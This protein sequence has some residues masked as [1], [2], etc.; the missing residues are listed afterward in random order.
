MRPLIRQGAYP[1]QARALLQGPLI[2][3]NP[4]KAAGR[5]H[6]PLRGQLGDEDTMVMESQKLLYLP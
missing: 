1:A 6:P 4:R 5:H 2:Q 3:D